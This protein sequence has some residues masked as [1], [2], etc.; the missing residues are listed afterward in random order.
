MIGRCRIDNCICSQSCF[1]EDRSI[2]EPSEYRS[3]PA[4]TQRLCAAFAPDEAADR[5]ARLEQPLGNGLSDVS[6]GSSDEDMHGVP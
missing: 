3:D 5:V 4:G 2:V 6:S 1:P